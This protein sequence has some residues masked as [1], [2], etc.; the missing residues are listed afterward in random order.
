M[1]G[2][3]TALALTTRGLAVGCAPLVPPSARMHARDVRPHQTLE[4]GQVCMQ[5]VATGL[6]AGSSAS[7]TH[8]RKMQCTREYICADHG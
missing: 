7:R 2:C 1:V 5:A 8:G 6:D 3:T 4:C